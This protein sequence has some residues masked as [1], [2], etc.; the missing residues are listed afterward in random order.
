MGLDLP[1]IDPAVLALVCLV[2]IPLPMSV[3]RQA[4]SEMFR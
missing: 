2:I 4:L 3:V 1:Y